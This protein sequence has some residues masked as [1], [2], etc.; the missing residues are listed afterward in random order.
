MLEST[1]ESALWGIIP[2]RVAAPVLFA[3]ALLLTSLLVFSLERWHV[4]L[5]KALALG[6]HPEDI[7]RADVIK[8]ALMAVLLGVT[9]LVSIFILQHYRSTQS[10][11]TRI[12]VLSRHILE[13]MARG[14]VTFDLEGGITVANS[15]AE[16]MLMMDEKRDERT[17]V[18]LAKRFPR[19]G[20]LVQQAIGEDRYAQDTDLRHSAASEQPMWLRVST[21]PLVL[22]GKDKAGVV[23][24]LRDVTRLREVEKQLRHID[25]LAVTES[26]AAG[27]AHEI[28]N[29]LTAIDLNLRL[30]RDE[31]RSESPNSE[32]M[33][34]HLEILGEETRRLNRITEEFLVFS[35]RGSSPRRALDVAGVVSH[36]LKLLEP[37]A[38]E[39]RIRMQNSFATGL[40]SIFGDAERLEQ[41]FLNIL[42]NT[43]EAMPKGGEVRVSLERA[44]LDDQQFLEVS[45][46]DQGPGVREEEIPRLFDPY[47]TTKPNGTGLGLAIAHRI[48]T[49]HDGEIMVENAPG[50][51]AV[52]K[53]RLPVPPDEAGAST[54]IVHESQPSHR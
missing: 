31:L 41:V 51:G 24:L 7:P 47:F 52:V 4:A 20:E 54:D 12:Q 10:K 32:E 28:R 11:L 8:I 49:D 1:D 3:L 15:V 42:V 6:A 21:S 23:M 38:E 40:P 53:V 16:R 25:R 45:V 19:L 34:G 43:M 27:V 30:L 2:Y 14:V 46:T 5:S 44:R 48:V 9:A 26:L 39:K 18:R 22:A 33:Q 29:P 36:V 35:R 13:N 17:L 37:E 50:G